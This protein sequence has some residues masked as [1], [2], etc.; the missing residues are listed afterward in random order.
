MADWLCRGLQSL[1][2]G[3]DSVSSL[4]L[5]LSS[6]VIMRDIFL[7]KFIILISLFACDM[8]FAARSENDLL[9]DAVINNNEQHVHDILR[10]GYSPNVQDDDGLTP[11][12][13]AVMK[14]NEYIVS[15][16]LAFGA[17]ANVT[18]DVYNTPLHFA[19]NNASERII[20]K[21]IKHGADKNQVN[22]FGVTPL[23]MAVLYDNPKMIKILMK[24]G[25]DLTTKSNEG[26]NALQYAVMLERWDIMHVFADYGD[27]IPSSTLKD[28][29]KT[30]YNKVNG[31]EIAQIFKGII[32]EEQEVKVLDLLA[33]P[34]EQQPKHYNTASTVNELQSEN[35]GAEGQNSNN[36]DDAESAQNNY[37]SDVVN[38]DS[39]Q[40]SY[41]LYVGDYK[42]IANAEKDI[43]EL[44]QHFSESLMEKSYIRKKHDFFSLFLGPFTAQE[45]VDNPQT[46]FQSFEAN[47]LQSLE[48][49]SSI[50]AL[51]IQHFSKIDSE[52]SSI[53]QEQQIIT[54]NI[55]FLEI[56][57]FPNCSIAMENLFALQ[58]KF[59]FLETLNEQAIATQNG[60]ILYIGYID[61]ERTFQEL[62]HVFPE[63][64]QEKTSIKRINRSDVDAEK[65]VNID[66]FH[67]AIN[68]Y[69]RRK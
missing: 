23:I 64:I 48:S 52:S 24:K 28:L 35:Y 4:I 10:Q 20:K 59:P 44:Q 57:N 38:D 53:F 49:L 60:C 66:D 5:N 50:K 69:A 43:Q 39:N 37:I 22:F 30:I 36:R 56:N 61:D 55:Y 18:D 54:N 47:D 51:N 21:L 6:F 1:V 67:R 42:M 62:K 3:F 33:N 26:Y 19:A 58:D 41:F 15:S 27:K 32:G 14:G 46:D 40:E 13:I 11:L 29:Y 16:L 34:T 68:Q 8:A 12:I 2:E 45:M 9:L 7:L 17:D 25:V 63:N 65:I 31:E